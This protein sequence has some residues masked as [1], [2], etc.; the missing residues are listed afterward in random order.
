MH[1]KQVQTEVINCSKQQAYTVPTSK[2]LNGGMGQKMMD[3]SN[4]NQYTDW[5]RCIKNL[6]KSLKTQGKATGSLLPAVP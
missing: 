5:G 1:G 6:R 3:N 4:I 2:A